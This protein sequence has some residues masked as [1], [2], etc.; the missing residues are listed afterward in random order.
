MAYLL[1]K[2]LNFSMRGWVSFRSIQTIHDILYRSLADGEKADDVLAKW[3]DSCVSL[4]R[5]QFADKGWHWCRLWFIGWPKGLSEHRSRWILALF[6]AGGWQVGRRFDK[7]GGPAVTLICGILGA[8]AD[9]I[10][11]SIA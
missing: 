10:S 5:G 4:N 2:V 7:D 9:L 11:H 1:Q 3:R 6:A 8:F